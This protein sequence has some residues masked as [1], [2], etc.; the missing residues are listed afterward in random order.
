[1]ARYRATA[2]NRNMPCRNGVVAPAALRLT[3]GL[4][5]QTSARRK[6]A[7]DLVTVEG[8]YWSRKR[9]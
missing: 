6:L 2:Q 7:L 3:T 8:Y 4:N 5:V 1:M 9:Y